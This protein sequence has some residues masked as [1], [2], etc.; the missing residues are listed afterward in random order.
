MTLDATGGTTPPRRTLRSPTT[1]IEAAP[2]RFLGWLRKPTG[3]WSRGRIVTVVLAVAAV[4]SGLATFGALTGSGPFEPDQNTLIVLL[5]IDLALLLAFGVIIVRRLAQLLSQRQEDMAGSRLRGRLVAAFSLAATVPAVL[6]GVSSVAFFNMGIDA[7]FSKQVQTAIA[8]STK[9]AEAYLEEHRNTLRANALVLARDFNF[10][11]PKSG[12]GREEFTEYLKEQ[13]KLGGISEWVIL[14]SYGQIIMQGSLS[15]GLGLEPLTTHELQRADAGEAVILGS[16]V[17]DRVRAL[18][19]LDAQTYL[20]AGR[21]VDPEV[22]ESTN[23]VRAAANSYRKL[24]GERSSLQLTFTLFYAVAAILLLFV[25][26]WFALQLAS[27]LVRPVTALAVAAEKIRQDDLSVRVPLTG[28]SDEISLLGQAFNRMA[29]RIAEQRHAL[30]EANRDLESRRRFTESVLSGVS[31]GVIGLDGKGVVEL[32]NR[33]AL[34]LLNVPEEKL[35]G[36][37]LS[38]TMPE[39]SELLVHAMKERAASGN[40]D[41]ESDAQMRRLFVRIGSVLG[42]LETLAPRGGYVV[43]IDDVTP[44]ELAQRKAAWSDVALRVAHEIKNPLTPIGLSAE[45][46]ERRFSPQIHDSPDVFRELTDTIQ[47]Q[48]LHM[49][50]VVN[51]FSQHA[52]M[53]TLIMTPTNAIELVEKAIRLQEISE[54]PVRFERVYP[55]CSPVVYC[56]SHMIGAAIFNIVKNAVEAFVITDDSGMSESVVRVTV[57]EEGDCCMIHVEDN[58]PGFPVSPPERLLEPHETHG[59]VEGY[60]L[61]LTIVR[62]TINDHGGELVLR[63]KEGGGASV[64]FSLPLFR[65]DQGYG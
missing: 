41:L 32:A 21:S 28:R 46:L 63:N 44:L 55:E 29:D 50:H 1:V 43:T 56:D 49:A 23:E 53:P 58:G 7:W 14:S 3:R 17:K 59:K 4:L 20:L 57:A 31:A 34:E 11:V 26:V 18:V 40:V 8:Q 15:T 24:E 35:V 12:G 54:T 27:R 39:V 22:I 61:G 51:E 33:R 37:D 45:R 42:D 48:V 25:A 36:T 30:M 5:N 38:H 6:I 52:R 60:G 10:Y 16:H 2:R 64:S 9:I 19:R 47:R 13:A 65:E 62:S